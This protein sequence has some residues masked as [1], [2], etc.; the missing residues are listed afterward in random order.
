MVAVRMERVPL[1][2]QLGDDVVLV[3]GAAGFIGSALC[4]RLK[5]QGIRVHGVTRSPDREEGSVTRWW[6]GDLSELSDVQRIVSEVRPDRIVHLASHVAGAPDVDLVLPT[7]RSNLLSTVNLLLAANEAGCRRIV[8]TG[9]MVEPD[10]DAAGSV[11]NSPYAMSKWASSSYSRM[12]HALYD[13]PLL[14][15]R[16]FMV[17]GP[18]Q[19]DLRKLIPHVIL[20]LVKGERPR[21]TSGVWP[22]DWIYIDDV[23]EAFLAALVA[24]SADGGTF[25]VGS[26][27]L[28][29]IR[30]VVIRLVNLVG[31]DVAPEF[32]SLPDRPFERSRVADLEPARRVLGWEP[33]TPLDEGLRRTVEWYARSL[34]RSVP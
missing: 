2:S 28:V 18:G 33:A 32:G 19:R 15:L 4:A 1:S 3:T 8:T 13:L 21:L 12:F 24:P 6:R 25:D 20:S 34:H 30:D 27:S 23:V 26:G 17:Y 10:F 7:L 5:S 11:A 31:S 9:T 16:V 29:P 14:N 22:I